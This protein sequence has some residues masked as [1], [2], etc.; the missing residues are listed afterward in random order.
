[1]SIKSELLSIKGKR[2]LLTAEEVV[3][4]ARA[5]PKSK[6]YQA[7]EF[8]GWDIRKS[9]YEHWLWAARRLSL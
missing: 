5:H 9:A 2:E 7:P 6:L 4:W 3:Q 8:C 1:M